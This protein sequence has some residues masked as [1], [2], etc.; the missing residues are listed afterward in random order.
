MIS[1]VVG[2]TDGRKGR[3]YCLLQNRYCLGHPYRNALIHL[4][5]FILAM[6]IQSCISIFLSG[7]TLVT[8][9]EHIRHRDKNRG[10]S[11]EHVLDYR[12][13][14]ESRSFLKT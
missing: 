4:Y 12:E 11:R 1:F 6:K 13:H 2:N 9:E 5:S 3:G 8:F 10:T 14:V 7:A